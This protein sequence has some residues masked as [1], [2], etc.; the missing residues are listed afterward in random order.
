MKYL[1]A[2]DAGGAIR[3]FAVISFSGAARFLPI[4][5]KATADQVRDM[6]DYEYRAIVSERGQTIASELEQRGFGK[7]Q[8]VAIALPEKAADFRARAVVL[9]SSDPGVGADFAFL[10]FRDESGQDSLKCVAVVGERPRFVAANSTAEVPTDLDG[11]LE[12]EAKDLANRVLPTS[13]LSNAKDINPKFVELIRR[14]R[15]KEVDVTGSSLDTEG[16]AFP[17]II[18]ISG[19][20]ARG[21][22]RNLAV[23]E[24]LGE[25][26]ACP[27]DSDGVPDGLKSEIEQRIAKYQPI[28]DEI[29]KRGARPTYDLLNSLD[30]RPGGME[31]YEVTATSEAVRISE[32]GGRFKTELPRQ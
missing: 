29:R 18:F 15:L 28:L 2:K 27:A 16:S 7:A 5:P 25:L 11:A 3:K 26:L 19:L 31:Q 12:N 4:D 6:I 13:A 1:A 22:T 17:P 14:E 24:C 21:E 20:S 30:R 23:A 10:T 9:E 8:A 32:I